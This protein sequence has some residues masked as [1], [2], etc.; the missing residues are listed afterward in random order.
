MFLRLKAL[1]Q[2]MPKSQMKQ[3]CVYLDRSEEKNLRKARG[4]RGVA[5]DSAYFRMLYLEDTKKS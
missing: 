4:K 2:G 3:I 1:A 5:S